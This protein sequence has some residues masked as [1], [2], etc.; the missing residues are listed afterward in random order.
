MALVPLQRLSA[1]ISGPDANT[2]NWTHDAADIVEG[3]ECVFAALTAQDEKEKDI[4]E[5]LMDALEEISEEGGWP[6]ALGAALVAA[7]LFP[8]AAANM[9]AAEDIKKKR[10]PIAFAEGVAMGVE[11]ASADFIKA[12]FWQSS[13]EINVAFEQGGKIA[14][15]YTNAGLV[16]GYYQGRELQRGGLSDVF[17]R[18]LKRDFILYTNSQLQPYADVSTDEQDSWGDSQWK[19]FYIAMAGLFA[20]LHVTEYMK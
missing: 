1:G 12:N 8:F 11:A 5:Q 16:L 15:S 3:V 10:T 4:V 20:Q 14:Q 17:Y 13:P 2:I 6:I 19:N 7:E 9:G 18:D